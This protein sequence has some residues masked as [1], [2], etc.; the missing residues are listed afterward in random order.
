MTTAETCAHCGLDVAALRVAVRGR[1]FCSFFCASAVSKA[2]GDAPARAVPDD[3]VA[4]VA[5]ARR[6]TTVVHRVGEILLNVGLLA[7]ALV[8]VAKAR[9]AHG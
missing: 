1:V 9:R 7:Y 5:S 3:S 2:S 6:C 4:G 8:R